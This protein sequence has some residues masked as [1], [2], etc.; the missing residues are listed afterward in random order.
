MK[1]QAIPSQFQDGT[2]SSVSAVVMSAVKAAVTAMASYAAKRRAVRHLQ[3]LD[4][5]MLKDIGIDRSEI[6]SVVYTAQRDRMVSYD[7]F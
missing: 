4:A 1:V 5:R 2:R 3:S 6:K 7:S